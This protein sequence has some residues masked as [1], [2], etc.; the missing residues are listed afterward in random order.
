MPISVLPA[1]A[2]IASHIYSIGAL[3]LG[4][5]QLAVTIKFAMNRTRENARLVFYLS[6]IYLPLLWI[7][8]TA[9]R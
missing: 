6:I 8:M 5:A 3:V 4:V 1:I 7:V 2:G 9:T